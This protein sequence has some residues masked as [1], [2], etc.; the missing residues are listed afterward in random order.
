MISMLK[1]LEKYQNC[2]FGALE[3]NR[4]AKDLEVASFYIVGFYSSLSHANYPC[5]CFQMF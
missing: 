1:L 3:V 5:D 2:N 4:P